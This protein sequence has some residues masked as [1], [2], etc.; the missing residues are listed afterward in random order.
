RDMMYAVDSST[1]NDF[2]WVMRKRGELG[3]TFTPA[4]ASVFL[5]DFGVCELQLPWSMMICTSTLRRA[6]A[7]SASTTGGTVRWN[8]AIR[9]DDRAPLIA[10]MTGCR[11]AEEG[12]SKCAMMAGP[13]WLH[14]DLHVTESAPDESALRGPAEHPMTTS[15]LTANTTAEEI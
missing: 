7:A 13:L 2:S 9:I 3:V 5:S 4:S 11:P 10:S 6:A 14:P 12:V 1:T 15:P 8:I